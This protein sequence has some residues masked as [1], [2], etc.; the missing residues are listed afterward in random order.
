M[1][2]FIDRITNRNLVEELR[3]DLEESDRAVGSLKTKLAE[4]EE[5]LELREGEFAALEEKADKLVGVVNV[6]KMRFDLLVP[7][8]PQTPGESENDRRPDVR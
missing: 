2:G 4:R 7:V 6:L 8:A 1:R 3:S 5:L